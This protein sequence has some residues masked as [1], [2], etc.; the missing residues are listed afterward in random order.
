MPAEKSK[1]TIML[2]RLVS[3]REALGLTQKEAA[4]QL[5][6]KNYQTLLQIEQG[7]RTISAHELISLS[8]LYGRDL[9][10]FFDTNITHD[11]VP[12]WRKSPDAEEKE[13]KNIQREFLTF[14]EHYSNLESLLNLKRRWKDIQVSHEKD[15]FEHEGYRLI[16]KL[17]S[18]IHKKLDLGSRPAC[19][20]LNVLEND[21]RFKIFHLPLEG[22]SGACVVDNSL[23]VGILVNENEV[24]W[25]RNYDLAHELFHI[26]TWD[27]FSVKE[28]GDGIKRTR[29]ERYADAFAAS[30]LMPEDHFLNALKE[31]TTDDTIRMVDI[32]ELAMDFGVS[33]EAVLWRLVNLGKLKEAQVKRIL[34]DPEFKEMD[35]RFRR[36]HYEK[37]IPSKYPERFVSLA[38]RCLMEGKISRGIFAAYID[39]ERHEVDSYLAENG[40][41]EEH[42]EKIGVA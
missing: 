24:P 18:D 34:G 16:N 8:R 3:A 41:I 31:I 23:G 21:L 13:I 2:Q 26:M 28:I 33:S 25:R 1:A 5:G 36:E 39:K 40:F 11:P 35:R 17:S 42:Y 27:V 9:D 32:I 20:L 29:P 38:C 12:L 30:L 15:D 37:N 14:L 4:E 6:F 19:N 7:K 10:Y 22:V